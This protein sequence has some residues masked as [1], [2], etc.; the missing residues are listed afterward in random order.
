MPSEAKAA[1]FSI[2]TLVLDFISNDDNRF[3]NHPSMFT[4]YDLLEE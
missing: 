3:A 4:D 2:W 1:S